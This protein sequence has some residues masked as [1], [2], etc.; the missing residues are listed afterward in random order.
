MLEL[1]VAAGAVGGVSIG[2]STVATHAGDY[3]A[4]READAA[5]LADPPDR[6]EQPQPLPRSHLPLT[7]VVAQDNVYGA[8]DAELLAP[9]GTSR[10]TGMK[11]N[12]G[13]TSLS[14]RV[15]FATGGRASFKPEQIHPQSD[16]RREIA[17][18]KIDRLLGI[19][20]VPP[21]KETELPL[22]ELLDAAEP[23]FRA[24][25]TSRVLDEA[26]IRDGKLRGELSWWIPDIKL[27]KIGNHRV[28]EHDGRD[29]WTTYLQVGARIPP[30]MR[31][32][33]AQLS[34]L[35]LFDVLIDNADRWTGSNTEM[36]PDGKILY[37]M[38]N[39]LSFSIM[40]FG[41]EHNA[42][43]MRRIQV[44]PRKLVQRLRELTLEQVQKTLE[45]DP[46]SKLGP[47]LR[48]EEISAI[49]AR[50]DNMLRY[51][52]QLIERYGEDAVLAFP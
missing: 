3:L 51:I 11:L 39:T 30:G 2:V 45:T 37:F 19:G 23:G 46:N 22:Q 32:M 21:A 50:R 25:I 10:I 38:D 14:I 34:A 8:P 7:F 12:R 16:P 35:I 44:F 42:G 4:A 41:H 27:A 24:Y 47:L 52:D 28:D 13:G 5:T 26:T 43:A 29:I 20:H 31:D 6:L 40:K 18:F 33:L 17:A 49:I 15:D 1:A 48:P 36:S 9:L